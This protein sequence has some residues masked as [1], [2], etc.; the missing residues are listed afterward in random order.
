MK[1]MIVNSKIKHKCKAMLGVIRNLVLD[2]ILYFVITAYIR[3]YP[4]H[5]TSAQGTTQ[6]A[7][8][9]LE[10]VSKRSFMAKNLQQ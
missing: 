5:V 8:E 4:I 3:K 1:I 7:L 10:D 9:S 2:L 6:N